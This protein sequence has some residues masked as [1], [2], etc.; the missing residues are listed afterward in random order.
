[1]PYAHP[2]LQNLSYLFGAVSSVWELNIYPLIE[3]KSS[4]SLGGAGRGRGW[5]TWRRCNREWELREEDELEAQEQR[6]KNRKMT[7]KDLIFYLPLN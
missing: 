4:Y 5:S 1:M 7:T 3:R 2:G 6:N